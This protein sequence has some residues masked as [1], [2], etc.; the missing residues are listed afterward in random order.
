MNDLF[1]KILSLAKAQKATQVTKV[2]V[3]LG[4]LSHMSA[5]HFKEHFDHAALGT[6]AEH[7]EIEAE[8]SLDIY[9]PDAQVVVLKSIDISYDP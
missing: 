2:C 3:K 5:S 9:D 1:N 6:L 8:E 7:A 4:A